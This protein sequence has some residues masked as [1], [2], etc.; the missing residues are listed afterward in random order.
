M[1]CSL[2]DM[3][4]R[5]DHTE[6]IQLTDKDGS[7][8]DVVESV[9]S[10]AITDACATIDGYIGGRYKLPLVNA[11]SVLTRTACDLARY[12][13]YDDQLGDEH[14]VTKRYQSAIRYLEQVSAGKVQLGI[15]T[16]SSAPSTTNT[17]IVDSAGSVFARERSKGFI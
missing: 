2:E 13:L 3:R 14:Q 1:Y 7:A 12:Y 17:A 6:L 15:H 9:L 16:P 4:T 10:H 5:F 8:G 11:P